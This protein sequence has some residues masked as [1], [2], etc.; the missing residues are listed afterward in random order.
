LDD[1]GRPLDLVVKGRSRL[2]IED[3]DAD[4]IDDALVRWTES[5]DYDRPPF[6]VIHDLRRPGLP[7]MISIQFNAH[8]GYVRMPIFD[9]GAEGPPLTEGRWSFLKDGPGFPEI[10]I[11]WGGQKG[12]LYSSRFKYRPFEFRWTG[13]AP[14]TSEFWSV[15]P[16]PWR[17]VSH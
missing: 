4:G 17:G 7:V 8:A 15:N 9:S 3:L 11:E 14:G 16:D 6:L 10:V 12:D 2:S 5:F 13:P 1:A